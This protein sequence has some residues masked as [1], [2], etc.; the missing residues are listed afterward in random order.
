MSRSGLPLPPS[1]SCSSGSPGGLRVM[2]VIMRMTTMMI[3]VDDNDVHDHASV[4]WLFGLRC[5]CSLP[6]TFLGS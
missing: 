3:A 6:P 5:S 2:I 1:L 4:K